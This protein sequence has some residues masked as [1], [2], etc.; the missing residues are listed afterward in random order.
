MEETWVLMFGGFHL[1]M[2]EYSP[3]VVVIII[4]FIIIGLWRMNV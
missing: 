4:L 2:D 3:S 1:S